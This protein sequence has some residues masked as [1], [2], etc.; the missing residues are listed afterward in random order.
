M[1]ERLQRKLEQKDLLRTEQNY[2]SANKMGQ[3]YETKTEDQ[4][5]DNVN[6]V[7]Y[8]HHTQAMQNLRVAVNSGDMPSQLRKEILQ[9]LKQDEAAMAVDCGNRRRICEEKKFQEILAEQQNTIE[10]ER[11]S[12]DPQQKEQEAKE[13]ALILSMMLSQQQ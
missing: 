10:T 9:L 1:R 2:E 3:L 8:N 7:L 12:Q 11:I 5:T 4:D 13:E 6:D